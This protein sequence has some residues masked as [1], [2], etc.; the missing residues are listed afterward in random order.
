MNWEAETR[1]ENETLKKKNEELK[2]ALFLVE[3]ERDY[4]LKKT[5]HLF[6]ENAK[7]MKKTNSE[8]HKIKNTIQGL[9]VNIVYYVI[10]KD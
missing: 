7:A 6:N 9:K 10:L 3:A 5:G 8:Q 1:N 2:R 4:M